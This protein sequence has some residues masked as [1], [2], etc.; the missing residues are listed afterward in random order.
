MHT[1][2]GASVFEGSTRFRVWAPNCPTLQLEIERGS[3][4]QRLPMAPT[5]DGFF[6][7][8]VA[9]GDRLSA[10]ASGGALTGCTVCR[11]EREQVSHVGVAVAVCVSIRAAAVGCQQH[12]QV[13]NVHCPVGV[14]LRW[15]L[16]FD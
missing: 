3:R 12:E 16:E 5:V 8:D 13:R 10:T 1:S 14:D 7:R 2:L 15:R 9:E 4:L 6:E 11:K